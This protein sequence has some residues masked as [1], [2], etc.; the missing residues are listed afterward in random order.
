MAAHDTN[1]GDETIP[2]GTEILLELSGNRITSRASAAILSATAQADRNSQSDSYRLVFRSSIHRCLGAKL[3]ELEATVIVQE[4]AAALPSIE[5]L[6][7]GPEW[8][9]PLSFQAPRTVSILKA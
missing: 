8:I 1:L 5:L 7:Q 9:H 4:T 3:A 6:D 2:A